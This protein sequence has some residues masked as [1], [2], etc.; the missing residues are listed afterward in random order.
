MGGGGYRPPERV[1][2][3]YDD[4]WIHSKFSEGNQRY[5]DVENWMNERKA[6]LQQ[7]TYYNMPDGT[8]VKQSDWGTWTT[9]KFED[10]MKLYDQKL[11]DLQQGWQDSR[12]NQRD[13]YDAR[14]ADINAAVGGNAQA[15]EQQGRDLARQG[16]RSRQAYG[17]GGLNRGSMRIQGVNV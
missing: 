6:K 1:E 4:A 15:L 7:P 14:L 16:Q 2:N 17:T 8:S 12:R 5:R 10:Q 13:I 11:A 9:G 3:D